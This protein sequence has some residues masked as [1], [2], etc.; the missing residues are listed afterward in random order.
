MLSDVGVSEA[1]IAEQAYLVARGVRALALAGQ[2]DSEPLVML[3]V[4]TRLE[5][6]SSP[7]AIPFVVDRGDGRADFG[8]AAAGWVLDLYS[9]LSKD[10][11][12]AV[13]EPQRSRILG[14]LLGYST[15]A[16]RLFEDGRSGRLFT[17]TEP[18]PNSRPCDS[19]STEESVLHG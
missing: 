6:Q 8:F 14:L 1:L 12:D 10:T 16:I 13:P 11:Q 7:G 3:R 2:C 15:E 18:R 5:A 4:A 9:W 19:W 17:L